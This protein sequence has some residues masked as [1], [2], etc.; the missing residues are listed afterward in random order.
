[1]DGV[2]GR[3]VL[4]VEVGGMGEGGFEGADAEATGV[5]VGDFVT[6]DGAQGTEEVE[7]GFCGFIGFV[8]NV[9]D[10]EVEFALVFLVGFPL[11]D[12]AV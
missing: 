5:R 11:D 6:G 3:E 9:G 12:P 4:E 1:M 10:A 2:G 7:V 8:G